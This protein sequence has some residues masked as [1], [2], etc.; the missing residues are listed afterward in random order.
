[1]AKVDWDQTEYEEGRQGFEALPKGR[2]SARITDVEKRD[3]KR[4]DGY[5]FV[6]EF[7]LDG[8]DFKNRKVWAQL[9]VSNPSEVAQRIGRE[10]WNSLC[11]ACGFAIGAV[12]DTAKLIGK[13]LIV[14][15]DVEKDQQGSPRNRVTGFFPH[16]GSAA[17]PGT[18]PLAKPAA[19][20]PAAG[21]KADIAEDDIPF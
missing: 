3:T 6:P 18:M 2:Y 8:A 1:M 15:V 21:A 9:N 7:T 16:D 13:R 19:A 12:N 4:K 20:K 11:T 17:A 14:L 10:Q 5:M